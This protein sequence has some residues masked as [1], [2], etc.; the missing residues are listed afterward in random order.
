M[1]NFWCKA[2]KPNCPIC[3]SKGDFQSNEDQEI[4]P[5]TGESVKRLGSVVSGSIGPKMTK[6]EIKAD[7]KKRSSSH[8][9]K[10]ILPTLP[11]TERVH[12]K[13]KELR[14]NK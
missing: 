14:K 9:K 4:C 6:E 7:R 11:I 13:T 10:E 1:N 2:N 8:F 3:N 5:E 12:H